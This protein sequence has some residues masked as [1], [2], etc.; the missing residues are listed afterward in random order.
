MASWS[1]AFLGL[2]S[3]REFD[4]EQP[5][6]ERQILVSPTSVEQFDETSSPMFPMTS[7][8]FSSGAWFRISVDA[9][10]SQPL[11]RTP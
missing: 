3:D 8:L 4:F 6:E 11:E 1:S 7:L 5:R 2:V 10:D 9:V